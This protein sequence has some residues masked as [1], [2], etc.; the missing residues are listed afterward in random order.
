[1][2]RGVSELA[3]PERRRHCA[4]LLPHAFDQLGLVSAPDV[5][6]AVDCPPVADVSR[7]DSTSVVLR[8]DHVDARWSD[9]D[10]VDVAVRDLAAVQE[11]RAVPD[12]TLQV[13]C[14]A[15]FSVR[16]LAEGRRLLRFVAEELGYWSQPAPLLLDA[17]VSLRASSLILT[18]RTSAGHA[19]VKVRRVDRRVV[20]G[21]I[22]G[23]TVKARLARD[24][25]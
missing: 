13:R 5:Q 21:S 8:V 15:A 3:R 2:D 18:Q 19:D 6:T 12:L 1:M 14:E 22:C 11:D 25:L 20:I 17:L 4:D 23:G 9:R 24:C 10:V 16:A 7:F